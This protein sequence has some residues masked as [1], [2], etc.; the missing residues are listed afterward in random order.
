MGLPVMET[1]FFLLNASSGREIFVRE[2]MSR[3][4]S[5]QRKELSR[6]ME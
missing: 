6:V 2:G 5:Q 3:V 4:D 1:L